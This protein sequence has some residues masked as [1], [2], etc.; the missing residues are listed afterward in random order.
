[1][2]FGVDGK[3][4]S[5]RKGESSLA[6]LL[7]DAVE[8]AYVT[9]R[10]RNNVA[11][12]APDEKELAE[13]IG[14]SAI[15]FFDLH[16]GRRSYCLEYQNMLKLKGNTSVYLQYTYARFLSVY[17]ASDFQS[18]AHPSDLRLSEWQFSSELEREL[19]LHIC[20]F[21]DVIKLTADSLSPVLLCE[22]AIDLARLANQ[23]YE[24]SHIIGS[25][26][27]HFKIVLCF[28]MLEIMECNMKLLGVKVLKRI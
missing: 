1:M 10:S 21:Y 15:R 14:V 28:S 13:A 12:D 26:R 23:F 17:R 27:E 24:T 7:Q 4:L 22:Y 6:D 2:I 11:R 19:I 5:S 16:A 18:M 8:H 20:R 3:K 25:R 9:T